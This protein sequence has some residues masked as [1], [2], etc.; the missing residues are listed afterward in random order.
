MEFGILLNHEYKKGEDLG[1]RADDLVAMT[2]LARDSGYKLL[3]GMHHLLSSLATFQALPL[4]ARLIP[5]S[6]DMRLGT[7][8]YLSNL[9]HPIHIAETWASLDQ[10]SKGRVILGAGAGYRK[11]EFRVLGIDRKRRWSR[12]TEHI[13]LLK[14]LWTGEVVNFHGEHFT[15]EGEA[16]SIVPAQQ[17]LPIWIGANAEGTVRK[18][19]RIGDAWIAPPNVKANWVKGHLRYFLD[20]LD[21]L[22]VEHAGREYPLIREM[23]ISDTDSSAEA[24]VSEYIRKEYEE[25]SNPEYGEEVQLW[26]SM[27]DEFREKAFLFGSAD[28]IADKLRDYAD[29]GFNRFIFRVSWGDMPF[30]LAMQ[31]IDRFAKEVM[32]R[33]QEVRV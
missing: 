31:N 1:K 15:I 26:K 24:E 20:E 23:Y 2:H 12:M 9:E 33:F 21:Q 29:A 8:V 27:F 22:G 7:G 11:N 17:P 3:F 13:E 14:L 25:Y 28:T 16:C 5:E 6:G 10:L 19:A 32:P 4:L 30:E 18:A